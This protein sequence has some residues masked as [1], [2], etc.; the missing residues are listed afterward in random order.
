VSVIHDLQYL[1]FPEYWPLAKRALMRTFHAITLRRCD[2]VVVISQTVKDDLLNKYGS[3]WEPRVR[4]IWNSVSLERFGHSDLP[5][6][7]NGRPYILSTGVDRPSKNLS[8]LIKAF[9]LLREKSPEYCLVL[10][11]QVRAADR[12]WTTKS[13]QINADSPSSVDLVDQLGLANDVVITGFISDEQLGAL[14]RGAALFV[15]PSLFEGFGMP[16]VESLML[17]A[18][19]L[20]T[21]LPVLREVTIN[22]AEYIADPRSE[23]EIAERMSNIL[24]SGVAARPSIALREELQNR[25]APATI[26]QQYLAAMLGNDPR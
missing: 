13:Q 9:K 7:T 11:G 3:R 21:D 15:L 16:A 23:H 22:S 26:A 4:A 1:H 20:V 8:S 17:G 6:L 24:D 2:T 12:T 18:P 5:S 19:T 10:A 14:Y 25:F